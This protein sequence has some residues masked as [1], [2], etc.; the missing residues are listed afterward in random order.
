LQVI[1]FKDVL[2]TI[3]RPTKGGGDA[4]GDLTAGNPGFV[5]SFVTAPPVARTLKTMV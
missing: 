1:D 4:V 5:R 2:Q 3:H